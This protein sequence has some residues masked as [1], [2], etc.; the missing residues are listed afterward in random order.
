MSTT[1]LL[2]FEVA[3]KAGTRRFPVTVVPCV[4]GSDEDA[5]VRIQHPSVLGM[6]ALIRRSGGQLTVSKADPEATMQVD[7]RNADRAPI[8]DGI[9]VR[10]GAVP[11]RVR[12]QASMQPSATPPAR[13][14]NAAQDPRPSPSQTIDQAR[15]SP[16]GFSGHAQ[17]ALSTIGS[18]PGTRTL[19]LGWGLI[20]L[21]AA[22]ILQ[23]ALS[24]PKL[25]WTNHLLGDN[26][27]TRYGWSIMIISGIVLV[28]RANVERRAATWNAH[29][30]PGE[31]I[32]L[33]KRSLSG[34]LTVTDMRIRF[35]E[36][37]LDEHRK[38]IRNVPEGAST[39]LALTDVAGIRPVRQSDVA[40]TKFAGL[41]PRV[42][43]VSISLKDGREVNLPVPDAQEVSA[44]VQR[45]I[46]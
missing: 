31:S 5:G 45:M 41:I 30:D 21:G 24:T 14:G 2:T 25:G 33:T 7:G 36:A 3:T 17:A 4:I 39:D 15:A 44:V 9:V 12:M 46:Q 20:V 11:M 1:P 23:W 8:A 19:F 29:L 37:D 28:R 18:S 42:W 40:R 13:L 34:V 32:V 22:D 10:I 43:G 35:L 16:S 38:A 27:L 6:H 26:L